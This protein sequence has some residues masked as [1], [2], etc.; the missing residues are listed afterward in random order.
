MTHEFL[1]KLEEIFGV[2]IK[3]NI[4]IDSHS[5]TGQYAKTLFYIYELKEDERDTS[6]Y[7]KEVAA[8]NGCMLICI[9]LTNKT[10]V[11]QLLKKH[12][13]KLKKVFVKSDSIINSFSSSFHLE[14]WLRCKNGDSD[15]RNM[16]FKKHQPL[17]K[18]ILHQYIDQ[19]DEDVLQEGYI[20]LLKT[21]DTYDG[22]VPFVVHLRN[23]LRSYTSDYL[24]KNKRHLKYYE[25]YTEEEVHDERFGYEDEN[26]KS[27]IN[28]DTYT[29]LKNHLKKL[30]DKEQKIISMK[31]GMFG[32]AEHT[33]E[34]LATKLNISKSQAE[35]VCKKALAKVKEMYNV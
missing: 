9:K 26:I 12:L 22:T 27:F 25:S 2:E 14:L 8:D 29:V 21:I 5:F 13:N 34:T 35:R 3:R 7:A 33:Y 10:N 16:L 20:I 6:A 28:E 32:E 15:A 1:D 11:N 19:Y 4:T 23:K 17:V 24:L 30:T 31:Y 18:S